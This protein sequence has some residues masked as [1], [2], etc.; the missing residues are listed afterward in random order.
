MRYTVILLKYYLLKLIFLYNLVCFSGWLGEGSSSIQVKL[1]D[2]RDSTFPL[3]KSDENNLTTTIGMCTSA[4]EV[5]IPMPRPESIR[6]ELL[7]NGVFFFG[8]ILCSV[9][10]FQVF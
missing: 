10:A 7:P 8:V 4:W 9:P 2:G 6:K 1:L 3:G 5:S